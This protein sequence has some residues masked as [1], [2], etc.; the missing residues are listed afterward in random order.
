[1]LCC[2]APPVA[3][4][5]IIF[6]LLLALIIDVL[7]GEL[8][9]FLHPVV[10]MGKFISLLLR[11]APQRGHLIQLVYGAGLVVATT[12][13]FCA[14]SY[15]LLSYLKEINLIAYI[16]VAAI[17]L[18]STFSVK[19]LHQVAMRIEELLLQDNVP[20]AQVETSSLVSRDTSKLDKSL[21]V[22]ATVESVAE[23]TCDSFIAP[24]F[25]FLFFGVP[26]AMAYRVANT[27][28]AMI[29]YHY[30]PYEYLGKCAARWDDVLNFIP[31]RLGASIM[32]I[33]A[34][35]SGKSTKGAWRIG[36]RDH[37]KTES[38]NAG[39]LMS[40]AAGAL[41]VQLEKVGCYK[42]GDATWSLSPMT[43]RSGVKIMRMSALL[44]M[45]ICIVVEVV[46]FVC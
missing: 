9:S 30:L 41:R 6:I 10:G 40:T 45:V 3:G 7:F 20:R 21:L 13:L 27:L 23:N 26:G 1:M 15:F 46:R 44:W 18:K 22:A 34:Y 14:A 43:I 11:F 29:G 42:L 8:P 33:S 2:P 35:L 16:I 39:W 31:A 32:L 36:W 25:Y 17:V 37:N 4:V 28:D 38:P 5:E 24:L 12:A 19:K